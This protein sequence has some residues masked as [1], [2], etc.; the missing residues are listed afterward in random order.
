VHLEVVSDLTIDTSFSSLRWSKVTTKKNDF[1]YALT[2]LLAAEELCKLFESDIL[3]ETLK[4]P[5]ISHGPSSLN[6][7]HGMALRMGHR[8]HKTGG[9][10]DTRKGVYQLETVIVEIEAVLNNRLLTYVCPQIF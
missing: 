8:A 6:E 4:S 9:E 7:Y 1:R 3:E 10:E 5:R 2:Y